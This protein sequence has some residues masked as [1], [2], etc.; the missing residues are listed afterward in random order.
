MNLRSFAL[1]L[2]LLPAALF[3]GNPNAGGSTGTP[4]GPTVI[5][6]G[7][8]TTPYVISA[9]GAYVLGGNRTVSIDVNVIEIIAP[10]VTLDLSGFA[11]DQASGGQRG[12]M[13]SVV[14]NLEVRNGSVLHASIGIDAQNGKG[15]RVRDVR[16][17]GAKYSGVRSFAEGTQIERCRVDD[18]IHGMIV[19]GHGS[20]VTDCVLNAATQSGLGVS[21]SQG[22]MA[23]RV[24][25]TGFLWGF[26]M[27]GGSTAVECS[28][29]EC[30]YGFDLQ[31]FATLRDSTSLNNKYGVSSAGSTV[32]ITGTRI[33][34]NITQAVLGSYTAGIGN[35]IQ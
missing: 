23:V 13:A 9:P 18:A 14:E 1:S 25:A 31:T 34:N 4:T 33:S 28:A 30:L 26:Q 15:L 21:M 35:L 6:G 17:V 27:I 10:D 12:I 11:L 8:F 7:T 29:T 20:L 19:G 24:V 5:P 3:A 32:F 2:A 16:F 22:S